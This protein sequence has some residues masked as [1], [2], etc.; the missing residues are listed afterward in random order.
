MRHSWFAGRKIYTEKNGDDN[1]NKSSSLLYYRHRRRRS[2]APPF[3]QA[4]RLVLFTCTF[5]HRPPHSI[6]CSCSCLCSLAKRVSCTNT[7]LILSVAAATAATSHSIVGA[8]AHR[9]ITYSSQFNNDFLFGAASNMPSLFTYV[10]WTRHRSTWSVHGKNCDRCRGT[11]A[12]AQVQWNGNGY[13]IFVCCS[14]RCI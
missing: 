7:N 5:D 9:K 4:V 10:L 14:H 6:L 12:A 3:E 2:L 13:A 8:R 11:P 1:K